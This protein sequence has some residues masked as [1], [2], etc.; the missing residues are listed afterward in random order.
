MVNALNYYYYFIELRHIGIISIKV[1]YLS[2]K[3]N[4]MALEFSKKIYSVKNIGYFTL[5]LYTIYKVVLN[6]FKCVILF[7][8]LKGNNVANKISMFADCRCTRVQQINYTRKS[9]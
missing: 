4:A 1:H 9:I 2:R 5:H 3:P 6:F 7:K 8:F